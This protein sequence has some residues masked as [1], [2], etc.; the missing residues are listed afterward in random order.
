[1]R[2]H[3]ENMDMTGA[4]LNRMPAWSRPERAGTGATW[5]GYVAAQA[6]STVVSALEPVAGGRVRVVKRAEVLGGA[7]PPPLLLFALRM[8]R[9]TAKSLA[10]LRPQACH[11]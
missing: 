9:D 7:G 8:R 5:T 10:A 1:M 6:G 4:E 11:Q 3:A 2:D